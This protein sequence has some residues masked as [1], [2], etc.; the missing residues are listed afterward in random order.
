MREIPKI[1][2]CGGLLTSS[3]ICNGVSVIKIPKIYNGVSVIK[4]PKN[5]NGVSVIKF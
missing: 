3:K 2:A 4:I 5:Y 1:S